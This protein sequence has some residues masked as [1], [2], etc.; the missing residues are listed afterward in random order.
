MTTDRLCEIAEREIAEHLRDFSILDLEE[1]YRHNLTADERAEVL[2]MIR[3]AARIPAPTRIIRTRE[4]LAALD[5]DTLVVADSTLTWG[6]R[7]HRQKCAYRAAD[8][9][10]LDL[11]WQGPVVVIATGEHVRAARRALEEA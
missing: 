2:H 3:T 8:A 11:T 6:W 1:T 7:T 10:L 9:H 4:E 5:P